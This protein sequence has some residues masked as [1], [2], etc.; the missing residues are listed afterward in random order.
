MTTPRNLAISAAAIALVA[1][2]PPALAGTKAAQSVP[3]SSNSH[4]QAKGKASKPIPSGLL[5][6]LTRA[7]ENG[8]KGINRAIANRSRGC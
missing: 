7:N 3:Q 4:L 6:A 5:N 2:S 8:L 1:A